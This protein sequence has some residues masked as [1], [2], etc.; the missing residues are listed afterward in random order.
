MGPSSPTNFVVNVFDYQSVRLEWTPPEHPNGIITTYII[1]YNYDISAPEEAWNKD[2]KEGTVMYSVVQNLMPS[3][4]CYFM[5]RAST[6][7]GEGPPTDPVAV[8][9]PAPSMTAPIN[10]TRTTTVTAEP[11]AIPMG[12]GHVPNCN[13]NG[14][15]RNYGRR[16]SDV[17]LESFAPMLTKLPEQVNIDTKG[18]NGV[19]MNGYSPVGLHSNGVPPNMRLLSNSN[20]PVT[21]STPISASSS[22]SGCH[23]DP[24]GDEDTTHHEENETLQTTLQSSIPSCH[25]DED[26]DGGSPIDAMA[27]DSVCNAASHDTDCSQKL[28]HKTAENCPVSLSNQDKNTGVLTE[29][30]DAETCATEEAEVLQNSSTQDYHGNS[31]NEVCQKSS[32]SVTIP[33]L[34][35]AGNGPPF[36][37]NS[38]INTQDD[39]VWKRRTPSSCELSNKSHLQNHQNTRDSQDIYRNSQIRE[40]KDDKRDNDEIK[41][42]T[43]PHFIELALNM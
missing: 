12:N 21:V 37:G 19:V 38:K 40:G 14:Q 33:L 13:G 31:D 17:E 10:T 27:T 25:S 24:T 32:D 18:G 16:L 39:P 8:V 29:L 36:S 23:G 5:M 35:T 1:L 3:V 43:S 4:Q 20:T 15:A 9:L 41:H 2:E 28:P 11:T 7:V 42:D 22:S 34:S 26:E 6:G 30:G